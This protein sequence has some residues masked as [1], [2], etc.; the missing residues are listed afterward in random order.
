MPLRL[1][2]R[3][4]T[5]H[6]YIRGRVRG[7]RVFESAGTDDQEAAEAIRIRRENQL[8]ER[9]IFGSSATRTFIE[10]VDSYLEAGGE[11]LYIGSRDPK[12]GKL[13]GLLSQF[14]L[15]PLAAIGQ[16]R[17]DEAARKLYPA[18]GAATR[19]RQVYGPLCAI[20]NHAASKGW[21]SKPMIKGPKVKPTAVK[22]A[23]PDWLKAVLPHCAPKV[24]LLIMTLVY[25]GARLSEV[26]RLDWD[27]D[28]NLSERTLTFRTTKNGDMRTGHIPD[29]LL[30][31][32]ANEPENRRHGPLFAWSDK[33]HVYGPI[34]TACRKAEVPY[35]S[36]HQIGRHTF[37]T[38]LRL[39][40][41]RDLRGVMQDGGWKSINAVVRYSHVVP[42]ETAKAVDLLP[43]VQN[44]SNS[45]DAAKVVSPKKLHLRRK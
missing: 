20:L 36:P 30:I 27:A 9:S 39:Y 26:L 5:Y 29:S 16:D 12:T 42:G 24:R 41:K 28:V 23:T 3:K 45:Q 37:A 22:W 11:A 1:V 32:L 33:C 21:C 18:A 25:T 14:S 4:G 31:E 2:R 7:I 43:S 17:A 44:E 15:T 38:W 34:R 19:R 10:A 6:W 40:A 13:T 35:L 8:L